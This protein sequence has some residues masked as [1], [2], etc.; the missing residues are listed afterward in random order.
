MDPGVAHALAEAIGPF[1]GV[2]ALGA[3]PVALV[4]LNKHF[5]LRTKELELEA[6]LHGRESAA[7]IQAIE[8]RLSALEGAIG[9]LT[10]VLSG[11]DLPQSPELPRLPQPRAA[12]KP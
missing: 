5:K 7:R 3:I 2:T 8:T 1:L 4:F 12:Q 9:S 6:G 10:Q 11:P